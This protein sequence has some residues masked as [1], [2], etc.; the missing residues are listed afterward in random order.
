MP[1]RHPVNQQLYDRQTRTGAAVDRFVALFGSLRFIA[2]MTVVI[3]AWIVL[4]VFVVAVRWDPYP[5][6]LL[7][8]AFSAQATYAAP[9]I[10]LSQNRSAEQDRLKA[11]HD[12]QVN[13]DA[14]AEIRANTAI[15]Q[16]LYDH[17][18]GGPM[19]GMPGVDVASFQG[20]PG[21]W[22]AA[23][24]DYQWAAVKITELQ[25]GGIEYVNPDAAA[26]WAALKADGKGR[27]AYLFGHPSVSAAATVDFFAGELA[28]L[29]LEPGDAVCLDHETSDGLGAA[30]VAGWACTVMAGLKSR[31]G[32][33]PLAY[34]F[35][36][37]AEEGNCAGLGGYQLWISDP[38]HPAGHP[39]VPAPWK[40]FAIH[41]YGI[42]G[43]IDRDITTWPTL[44]AMAAAVGVTP[45][46]KPPP[47]PKPAAKKGHGMILV[48]PDKDD[49]PAGTT[50]PGVFL[51]NEAGNM[52]HVTSLD[53]NADNVTAYQSAGIEGPVNITWDEYLARTGQAAPAPSA[54]TS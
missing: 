36:D 53:A 42:T 26:D 16:Q 48:Q 10:L 17:L 50:W 41:Q 13:A 20:Q 24:G 37:F 19:T 9:L 52:L 7:N 18:T 44:T 45:A 32:R 1:H 46:P 54:P 27:V 47:A 21:Q 38:N 3:A 14:L 49:V 51:L 25:P 34:T 12:Y 39:A 4:N 23:A 35:V 6:I 43:A 40:T 29:G 2:W 8:L 22:R 31:F 33:E 5:F 11:E 30:Q 28:P 15:T